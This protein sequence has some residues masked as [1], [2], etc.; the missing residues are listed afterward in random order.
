MLIVPF[1]VMPGVQFGGPRCKAPLGFCPMYLPSSLEIPYFLMEALWIVPSTGIIA[2][3]TF[4]LLTRRRALGRFRIFLIF[5]VVAYWL[6]L[7]VMVFSGIFGL[8]LSQYAYNANPAFLFI[9]PVLALIG[10][11][12]IMVNDKRP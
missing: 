4:R 1:I 9:G 8:G 10:S 7:A 3:S 11:L 12:L 5:F 6:G 2:A